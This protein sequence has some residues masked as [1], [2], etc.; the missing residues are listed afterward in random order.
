MIKTNVDRPAKFSNLSKTIMAYGVLRE[1]LKHPAWFLFWSVLT[2]PRLKRKMPADVPKDFAKT[3][4]FEAWMYLRL[5]GKIG[6]DKALALMVWGLL[7]GR[8][9]TVYAASWKDL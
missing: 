9:M 3:V 6:Q 5:K 1:Y 7:P 4:A 2:L 8:A